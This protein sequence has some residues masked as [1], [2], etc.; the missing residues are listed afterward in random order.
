MIPQ[1][2]GTLE[3]FIG[4]AVMAVFGLPTGHGNDAERAL[5]AALALRDA[6]ASD[7]VL[8]DRQFLRRL[9]EVAASL[10]AVVPTTIHLTSA[11]TSRDSSPPD[12]ARS[13]RRRL[14]AD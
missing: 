10:E 9:E 7:A 8:G 13:T 6:L 1:H 5:A 3:K 12:G 2:G 11:P 4:D 14:S